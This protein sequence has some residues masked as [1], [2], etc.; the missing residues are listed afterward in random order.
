MRKNWSV[1]TPEDLA[2]QWASNQAPKYCLITNEPPKIPR[3]NK[4]VSDLQKWCL[5]SAS[6]PLPKYCLINDQQLTSK[7]IAENS[8]RNKPQRFRLKLIQ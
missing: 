8:V 1:I 6:S 4:S 2:K 5:N 3:E 7:T